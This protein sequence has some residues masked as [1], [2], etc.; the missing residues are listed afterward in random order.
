MSGLL[1]NKKQL[2]AMG[3]LQGDMT[4]RKAKE[5]ASK[6]YDP[7]VAA[8]HAQRYSTAK[9]WF[10]VNVPAFS[11]LAVA[12]FPVSFLWIPLLA[13]LLFKRLQDFTKAPPD[14]ILR[15]PVPTG[16]LITLWT[17]AIFISGL[18][19]IITLALTPQIGV[20]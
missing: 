3:I 2:I 12:L 20:K 9:L 18:G 10:W 16:V 15:Y 7:S 4:Y 6:G 11:F 14:K 19:W 1:P 5:V 8:F 13:V 17:V